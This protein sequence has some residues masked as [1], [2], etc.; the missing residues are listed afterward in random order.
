MITDQALSLFAMY[1]FLGDVVKKLI[2]VKLNNQKKSLPKNDY[3][4]HRRQANYG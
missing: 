3:E 4:S 2:K 1:I